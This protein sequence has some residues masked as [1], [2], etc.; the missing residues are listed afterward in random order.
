MVIFDINGPSIKDQYPIRYNFVVLGSIP[1]PIV[2][3]ILLSY[4]IFPLI[5]LMFIDPDTCPR[6]LLKIVC[7]IYPKRTYVFAR[8]V[9]LRKV[10]K[11]VQ[12]G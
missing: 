9:V 3:C 12:V 7:G 2:V 5:G 4:I 1:K 6:V 11:R 10:T 8:P